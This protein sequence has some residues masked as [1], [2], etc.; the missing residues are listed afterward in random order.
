MHHRSSPITVGTV[1]PRWHGSRT[2][3]VPRHMTPPPAAST[4]RAVL[5]V[6]RERGRRRGGV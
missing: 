1:A 6:L 3:L 4:Q 5:A 2:R